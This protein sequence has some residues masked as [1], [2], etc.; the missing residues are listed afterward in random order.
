MKVVTLDLGIKQYDILI[1][2]GL[3]CE[4]DKHIESVFTGNRIVVITDENL[5]KLHGGRLLEKLR[6]ADYTAD[7]IVI[8]PGEKSKHL[9]NLGS[10]Y[11]K[12]LDLEITRNDLIIAFGGGVVG[13]LA[14]FLAATYLRGLKLVQ[15]PTSLLAMVDSGIGGKVAVDLD[16]GKNLVG[17]FY[18]PEVVL[19]DPEL[20]KTLPRN[21][22]SNGM[23]E[24]IKYGC[25]YDQEMFD[26]I[27]KLHYNDGIYKAIVP[28]IFRSAQIKS[29]I[30]SND[31]LDRGER[32]LLNFGHTIGHA[33]EKVYNYEK[34]THGE[35][36]AIGMYHIT[37]NSEALGL[38]KV[39]TAN[40]IKDILRQF[41]LP[42]LIDD[43]L[44]DK[45]EKIM[46]NDKKR[47]GDEI[48]FILLK[49]IG[50]AYIRSVKIEK[51]KEYIK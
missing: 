38:T 16:E 49:D 45:I 11:K 37:K 3:F 2:N 13:D 28:I 5:S 6:E 42:V 27:S 20:L 35:A 47:M 24:V 26:E 32:M 8:E 25:I 39:G 43:M 22:F 9:N 10:L 15:I 36:V 7:E 50:E 19:I 4:I 12:L 21:E 29:E 48:N 46:K 51:I 40:Q 14:G 41:D 34:L 30:V 1:K 33:L 17:T 44:K 31:E 23:A 18:H